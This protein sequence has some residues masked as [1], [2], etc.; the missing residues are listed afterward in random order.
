M[1]SS[2]FI[3]TTGAIGING[4]FISLNILLVMNSFV[5]ISNETMELINLPSESQWRAGYRKPDVEKILQQIFGLCQNA[6]DKWY[7]LN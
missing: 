7:K 1:C 3:F 6:E 5:D 2:S 4:S